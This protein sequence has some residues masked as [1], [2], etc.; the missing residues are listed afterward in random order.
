AFIF[1]EFEFSAVNPNIPPDLVVSAPTGL[2]IGNNPGDIVV[3]VEETTNDE[4]PPNIFQEEGDA[5]ELT[6]T[7]QSVNNNNTSVPDAIQGELSDSSDTD[8]Y[9]VFLTGGSEFDASTDNDDTRN[10]DTKLYLFDSQGLEIASNDDSGNG[11]QSTL[12]TFN[13]SESGVYYVS[14]NSWDNT[15]FFNENGNL[16]GWNGDGGDTGSYTITLGNTI[17]TIPT[18]NLAVNSGETLAFIGGNVTVD[19]IEINSPSSNIIIGGLK[20]TG[21]VNINPNLTVDLPH[22]I[23]RGD[24]SL[25]NSTI[26]DVTGNNGGS[27]TL[28][29]QNININKSQVLAGIGEGLGFEDAQAGDIKINATE[30]VT[31]SEG[32]DIFSD[33]NGSGIGNSGGIIINTS[34]LEM[35]D[36]GDISASV[37]GEGNAGK[38]EINATEKVTISESGDIVSDVEEGGIGNT[39]GIL[40]NTTV[41]EV[42]FSDISASV[43]GQG[44]TGKIEINAT[45]STTISDGSELVSFVDEEGVGNTEG[46]TINTNTLDILESSNIIADVVG[47]GNSGGIEINATDG[48]TII[49]ESSFSADVG[50]V[51]SSD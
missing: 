29:G 9:S 8:L 6:N 26:L 38:I 15:P 50:S 47:E 27:I 7:A 4:T 34:T 20:E 14:V 21:I 1:D 44:N 41:L 18:G 48:I 2:R 46:I 16:T 11:F 32:S 37:F 13:V 49:S 12:P 40:I 28:N 23:N 45:E 3:K 42:D 31:I 19:G 22:G 51:F 43:S 30:K 39:G 25:I 33:V 10:I 24:I 17:E 35:L 36:N 5:G